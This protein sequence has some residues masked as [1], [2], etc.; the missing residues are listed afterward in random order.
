MSIV[1]GKNVTLSVQKGGN[2]F[3]ISCN[4]VCTLSL[5]RDMLETTY[6]TSGV[7]RS[8]LPGK[9][10]AT[11]DGSGPIEY[12]SSFSPS[13]VM[14]YLYAG[15]LI[16]WEFELLDDTGHTPITKTYSGQGYFMDVVTT[17]DIQQA[18]NIDYTIQ[19]SGDIQGTASPDT[20]P[21]TL[22]RDTYTATGGE[23]TIANTLWIN[24]SMLSVERNGIGLIIILGGTP[25]GNQVLFDPN[26]GTLTFAAGLPLFLDEYINTIFES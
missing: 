2:F 14:D 12:A 1:K 6:R 9:I 3:P 18:A 5:S 24:A 21:T 13:D 7:A 26:A 25:D 15:T 17:G 4:A 22:Q 10:N 16:S 11:I 8:F 20:G 19:V 23:V